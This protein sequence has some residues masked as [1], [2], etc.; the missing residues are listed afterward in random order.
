MEKRFS[1]LAS[2]GIFLAYFLLMKQ[3]A[4]KM[5]LNR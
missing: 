3:S 4:V 1:G 2:T 5:L